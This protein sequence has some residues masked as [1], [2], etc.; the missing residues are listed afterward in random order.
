MK[1]LVGVGFLGAVVTVLV[2]VALAARVRAESPSEP[3][4]PAVAEDSDRANDVELDGA[5]KKESDK[6]KD[7]G[8]KDAQRKESDRKAREP[9]PSDKSKPAEAKTVDEAPDG[10]SSGDTAPAAGEKPSAEPSEPDAAK[11]AESKPGEPKTAQVPAAE[12]A[13]PA[14]WKVE[15]RLLRVEVS[16]DGVFEAAEKA[17]IRLRLDEWS[18]LTVLKAVEHGAVVHRGDLLV[19]LETKD[20]DRA[21]ADLKEQLKF[22][23][24]AL[25]QTERELDVLRKTTPLDVEAHRRS[26]QFAAED[27]DFYK[28]VARPLAVRAA[29]FS[30]KSA[31]QYLEYEEEELRQLEKMYKADD[32][33]EETEEIVLKRAR[34]SVE[35]ARFNLE[36]ARV[37]TD[38]TLKVEIPRD[39]LAMADAAKKADW[40]TAL[41]AAALPLVLQKKE[42]DLAKA[43]L[44]RQRAGERLEKLLAD[45]ERM[46]VKSPIDGVVYYGACDGGKWSGYD[47]A[48]ESLRPGGSLVM[49]RAF[50]T[51]VKPRPLVVR[52][53]VPE[54]QLHQVRPGVA[55]TVKPSGYPDRKLHAIVERVSPVPAGGNFDARLTVA[56]AGDGDEIVAGMT[57]QAV[58]VAYEKADAICVPPTALGSDETDPDK[59]HVFVVGK[60]GKSQR[61]EVVVGRRTDKLVEIVKGLAA[62]EEVLRECP[63]KD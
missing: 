4:V 44:Q 6:H 62:G 10:Q 50:M 11:P 25:A 55:G 27:Y 9:K 36:R 13:K 37:L 41:Q 8:R 24:I 49:N 45:R 34:N 23:D 53:G 20:I 38:R 15:K 52:A 57:C 35:R 51:V 3:I 61:R 26:R 46:I 14:T 33:T 40:N 32:L 12:A 39:D 60:D 54:K 58:L 1:R 59:K 18:G 19:T 28:K 56:A 47:T 31:E 21:I 43:R 17:E 22:D 5:D 30:L 16:L 2:V 48:R 63:K 42:L 7:A 29:E